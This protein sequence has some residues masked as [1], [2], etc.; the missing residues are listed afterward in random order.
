MLELS[1][2]EPEAM[3][4]AQEAGGGGEGDGDLA[5][6]GLRAAPPGHA[7]PPLA[8]PHEGVSQ[9]VPTHH[10]ALLVEV[11]HKGH[12]TSILGNSGGQSFSCVVTA[13][14]ECSVHAITLMLKMGCHDC[15]GSIL[16]WCS[17]DG[18]ALCDG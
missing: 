11:A 15:G 1:L 10:A 12:N 3:C 7:P 9:P 2:C 8:P 16:T 18:R 6:V 5:A 13:L 4:C 17:G 14:R